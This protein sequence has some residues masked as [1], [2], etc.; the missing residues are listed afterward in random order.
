MA[1][2]PK[3]QNWHIYKN[4]AAEPT[5]ALGI[6]NAVG[7]M[8]DNTSIIRIR[9]TIAE[10]AGKAG[11]G[12]VTVEYSTDDS[13]FTAFGAG[14]AWNYADGMG[15][16]ANLVTT[17]LCTDTSGK[18]HYH[19]TGTLS[20]SWALSTGYELDFAVAPTATVGLGAKYYFRFKIAG[21]IVA[22]NTSK[23]HP[24]V[25]TV[26]TAAGGIRPGPG[27]S[28]K[29]TKMES[30]TKTSGMA[31]SGLASSAKIFFQTLLGAIKPTGVLVGKALKSLVGGIASS[32]AATKI[33]S[34]FRSLVGGLFKPRPPI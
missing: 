2:T 10:T 26:R 28:V 33:S 32:G 29:L 15:A 16:E 20:E 30:I 27:T 34:F 3:Q 6:E 8:V 13:S 1:F 25:R 4:D 5:V 7:M 21:S 12:A 23:T 11:S 19:E 24:Q 31:M 17:N 22:L 9:A 18:M 14:N